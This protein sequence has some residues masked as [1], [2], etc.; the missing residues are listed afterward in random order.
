MLK[1]LFPSQYLGSIFELKIEELLAQGIKGI[2]FDI[3]NTLVPYDEP[4]PTPAIIEL[5]ERIRASGIQ[6]TLVSNNTEDRVLR[7]NEKIKV[8]AL[9]KSRK[10]LPKSFNK[11]LKLMNCK[12]HEAVIVGDQIFTD[13]LGGNVAKIPAILVVPVSDKDERITKIKRG[14]E[15]KVIRYYERYTAKHH[16]NA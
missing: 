6:I 5:F 16:G 12:P 7:F 14:L 15:K 10:P 2:I 9:H 11:A 1:I 8:F 3:D 4:E 13:V